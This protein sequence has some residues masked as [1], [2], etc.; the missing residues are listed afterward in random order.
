MDSCDICEQP[1][2]Y[3]NDEVHEAVIKS[4]SEPAKRRVS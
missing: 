3:H 4:M 1:L 2:K